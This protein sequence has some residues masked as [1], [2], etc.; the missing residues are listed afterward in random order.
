MNHML[1]NCC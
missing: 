1:P